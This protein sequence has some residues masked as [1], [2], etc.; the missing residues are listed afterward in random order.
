MQE[1]G[2]ERRAMLLDGIEVDDNLRRMKESE[3]KVEDHIRRLKEDHH[4]HHQLDRGK[5][6]QKQ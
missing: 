1:F 5:L 2:D 4:R 6:N 3:V